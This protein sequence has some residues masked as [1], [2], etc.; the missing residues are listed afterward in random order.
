MVLYDSHAEDALIKEGRQLVIAGCC[1]TVVGS[2][3]I[4]ALHELSDGPVRTVSRRPW[5]SAT[6]SDW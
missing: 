1:V 3:C 2:A 5:S 4:L 6:V